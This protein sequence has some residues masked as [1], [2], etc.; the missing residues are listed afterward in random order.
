[1]VS[2]KPARTSS[3]YGRS[4]ATERPLE[5]SA[6]LP[7]NKSAPYYPTIRLKLQQ[8]ERQNYPRDS[9][10]YA[11]SVYRRPLTMPVQQKFVSLLY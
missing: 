2:S 3:D 9:G 11:Y 10:Y 5:Q 4:N 1:M 7:V 6:A 8:P